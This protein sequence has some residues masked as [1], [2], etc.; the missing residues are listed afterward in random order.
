MSKANRFSVAV[1]L[2]AG[3]KNLIVLKQ[4]YPLLACREPAP[5]IDKLQPLSVV[6]KAR[7]LLLD[8][9]STKSGLE[10]LLTPYSK[11]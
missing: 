9:A 10:T 2:I 3:G 5:H 1:Q 4:H 8:S 7:V 11:N 6:T